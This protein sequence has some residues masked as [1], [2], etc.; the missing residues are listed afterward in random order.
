MK[1]IY[2]WA[3]WIEACLFMGV[4]IIDSLDHP[5][6][7]GGVV[8]GSARGMYFRE[9]RR[10]WVK[11]YGGLSEIDVLKSL[12]HELGHHLVQLGWAD[13]IKLSTPTHFQHLIPSSWIETYP[14]EEQ[15]E[16][17]LVESFALWALSLYKEGGGIHPEVK[18]L[19][20]DIALAIS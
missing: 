13:E 2:E 8:I 1:R 3:G 20:K 18:S 16:E 9:A 6:V 14:V 15:M 19:L 17:I 11:T 5:L 10:C 7:E 4:D 12:F